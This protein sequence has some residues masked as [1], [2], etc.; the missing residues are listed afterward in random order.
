[1]KRIV[2]SKMKDHLE[3]LH[4]HNKTH[5]MSKTRLYSIWCGMRERCLNP[6]NHAFKYYGG[7]GITVCDEWVYDFIKFYKDMGEPP[8][9]LHSID[10][11]DSAKG[12]APENCRWAT[13]K[14]QQNNLKTNRMLTFESVTLC[15]FD[16]AKK[17]GIP[18][19]TIYQRIA[20]GYPVEKILSKNS[21]RTF[22]GLK[23]G[24]IANGFR[25]RTKTHCKNG[26]E[27]DNKNTG[28]YRGNRYC[29]KCKAIKENMR[30]K[31]HKSLTP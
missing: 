1:M 15:A 24:G 5:G 26:H 14:Q 27:F 13:K 2:S 4:G 17:L 3:K 7:N 11:I 19:Q 12:Y 9:R 31:R 8:S 21:F 18:P 16:W 20:L 28:I 29:K 6:N 25:Q 10:R 23:I 30:R 22:E